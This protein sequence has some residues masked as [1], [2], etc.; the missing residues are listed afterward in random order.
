MTTK[1]LG[2][3]VLAVAFLVGANVHADVLFTY[4]QGVAVCVGTRLSPKKEIPGALLKTSS[5]SL[6][7]DL[8]FSAVK[9]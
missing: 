9:D 8:A 3:V 1:Y 5:A 6:A 2:S 4:Q 7:H